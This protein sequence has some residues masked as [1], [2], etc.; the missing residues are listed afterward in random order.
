[1]S[2]EN[3]N[4]K[5]AEKAKEVEEKLKDKKEEKLKDKKEEKLK[6]KK[7]EKTEDINQTKQDIQDTLN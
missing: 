5:A 2:N 1:M 7:E 3:Q 6:D 4:K